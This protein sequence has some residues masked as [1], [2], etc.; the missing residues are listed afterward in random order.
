M[1][2][3]IKSNFINDYKENEGNITPI[4]T[5]NHSFTQ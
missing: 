2:V 3:N 5:L 4:T 1:E